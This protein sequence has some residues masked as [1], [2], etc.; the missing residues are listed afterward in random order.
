MTSNVYWDP[1]P[2]DNDIESFEDFH[3][4][5]LYVV[6]HITPF[7]AYGEYRN[8]KVATHHLVEEEEYFDTIEYTDFDSLVDDLIDSVN[9]QPVTDTYVVT[10]TNVY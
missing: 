4:P 10:L 8:R 5:T 9:S 1:N 6:D 2:Y 7:N 3:D